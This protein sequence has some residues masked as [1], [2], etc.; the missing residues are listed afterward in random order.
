VEARVAPQEDSDER[1]DFA[2]ARQCVD[3]D[4]RAFDELYR[5]HAPALGR[6]LLRILG[7]PDDVRDVMQVT[8]MEL[9]RSLDKYDAERPFAAWL[10]GFAFFVASRHLKAKRRKWWLHFATPDLDA[11][12]DK[13]TSLDERIDQSAQVR[14]VYAALDTLPEKKRIAFALHVLEGMSLTEI[15]VS[16]GESPQTIRAR[17]ESA[18]QKIQKK[19]GGG[20]S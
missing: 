1:S 19:L 6:R 3:G 2:L 10:N 7:R 5:R 11:T 17:V 12:R 20:V 18:R 8:F 16:L 13:G 4:R 14:A 15:G 9:H